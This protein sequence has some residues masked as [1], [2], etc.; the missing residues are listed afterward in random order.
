M[1]LVVGGLKPSEEFV[2]RGEHLLGELGGDEVLI[3]PAL[4]Q[5]RREPLLLAQA[6]EAF[7]GEQHGH[8]REDR[9]SRDLGHRLDG[10]G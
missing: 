8:G 2:E 1:L 7:L 5:D 3:L 10:K 4:G 6:E 9:A